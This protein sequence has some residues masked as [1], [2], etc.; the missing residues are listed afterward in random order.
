MTKSILKIIIALAIIFSFSG[1][2]PKIISVSK[3]DKNEKSIIIT[4]RGHLTAILRK[5]FRKRGW[6]VTTQRGNYNTRG[7]NNGNVNIDKKYKYNAR[8]LLSYEV[9]TVGMLNSM[10]ADYNFEIT[11]FDNK[12][13][14]DV[15]TFSQHN[16]GAAATKNA[17][18]ISQMI[19]EWIKNNVE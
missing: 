6:K 2:S 17:S 13:E 1:C 7:I 14:E 15:V 4:G 18:E 3:I 16:P 5:D 19:M 12:L 11:I 8:Y 9:W 10:G